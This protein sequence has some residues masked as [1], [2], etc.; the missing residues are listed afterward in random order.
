M[1]KR[2]DRSRVSGVLLQPFRDIQAEGLQVDFGLNP[3][4]IFNLKRAAAAPTLSAA[5]A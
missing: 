5:L 2:L 4:F 1:L 3:P